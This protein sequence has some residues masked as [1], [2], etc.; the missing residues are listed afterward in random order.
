MSNRENNEIINSNQEE[1]SD[2]PI[3]NENV[4]AHMMQIFGNSSQQYIPTQTQVDKIL[5]LQEKGMDYT[6]KERMQDKEHFSPREKKDLIM[7][8]FIVGVLL[9]IL[10][11]SMI[12]AE[13]YVG[14]V[15]IGT[16]GFLVGG[17]G[18]YGIGRS[19]DISEDNKD[20]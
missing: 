18:G 8:I 15:M 3:I 6:H 12:F 7:S 10:I 13:Q 9:V 17:A 4:T 2:M 20:I 1:S 14:E 16:L 11:L 19:K 5:E